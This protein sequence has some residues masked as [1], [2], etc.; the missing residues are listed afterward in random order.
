VDSP[1]ILAGRY[2]V[3]ELIGRGG[4]ADVL[5][6]RDIRLGRSVAIKQLRADL[7]RDP[8]LQSRFR[9]EAQAVAGLNHPAIVAVYDTG[10][11]D[12]PGGA[13]HDVRVP[14]I[15]MEYVRGRTLREFI[16]G[17]ELGI[18]D[19]VGYALGILA[20]LE[21]S[22]RSG[23]VHRDIKPANVMVT[24]DGSVKVM[25]FGIAR[26]LADSAATM[27]QTQAVLGTAQYLSPEQAR[28]ETVDARSD[29]YSAGCLLYEM[30]AG[31]PPFIGDS[32]VSVAYQHVRE[33]PEPASRFNPEVTP[34]LDSV[35]EHALQKDRADR[36]QTAAA[37]AEALRAALNGVPHQ[38]AG[39]ATEAFPA[40]APATEL[41]TQQARAVSEPTSPLSPVDDYVPE[42]DDGPHTASYDR[43]QMPAA[44]AVGNENDI[45]PERRAKRRAWTVTLL[46]ALLLVLVGGGY[47]LYNVLVQNAAPETVPVPA[48]T[49]LEQN[50]ATNALWEA[51]LRPRVE[52]EFSNDVEKDMVT[53]TDPGI[54][55][56]VEPGSQVTVFISQGRE[57]ATVPDNL[58][59]RTEAEVRDKLRQLGLTPGDSEPANSATL[60]RGNVVT[61]KPAPG[62]KVKTGST[63]DLIV[64]NGLVSV[65]NM[66]DETVEDA[67]A[68]LDDAA[69]ALPYRVEEVENEVVKAGTVV[70]QSVKAGTNVEQGTEIVLTVAVEPAQPEPETDRGSDEGN[71]RGNNGD[72]NNGDGNNSDNG[73]GRGND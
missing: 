5:L 73:N 36:F 27:T 67:G 62:K 37:F 22:H 61:T 70:G 45:E 14:F 24:P 11:M 39:T 44:L 31:R 33:L 34:A 25:D 51:G 66:V 28:G 20:A 18:D 43:E 12:L 3:G 6:G 48:V 15:V 54:G 65:P 50:E 19:S 4:M 13:A 10:D 9:R 38:P 8:M 52:Q 53:R 2:E 41:I 63:V 47:Y 7:A 40:Q 42:Y 68:M 64:S 32:P 21:Y 23:I 55:E 69:V 60:P 30:L 17:H 46:I 71:N 29:L 59:G 58:A 1:R 26:A 72:G 56:Q 35:L 57:F 49:G 16:K